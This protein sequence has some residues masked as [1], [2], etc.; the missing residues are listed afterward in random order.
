MWGRRVSEKLNDRG[1]PIRK[2]SRRSDSANRLSHPDMAVLIWTSQTMI[3]I[4]QNQIRIFLRFPFSKVVNLD[5][6][7]ILMNDRQRNWFGRCHGHKYDYLYMCS[8]VCNNKEHPVNQVLPVLSFKI[9][10]NCTD[11][12]RKKKP[13]YTFLKSD[14]GAIKHTSSI[15]KWILDFCCTRCIKFEWAITLT[16]R[17]GV[18]G[19]MPRGAWPTLPFSGR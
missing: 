6:L 3:L 18:T 7:N 19:W 2:Y 5:L 13:T 10:R 15:K 17:H 14:K 1:F 4:L 12:T 9:D 16:Q 11:W 8:S